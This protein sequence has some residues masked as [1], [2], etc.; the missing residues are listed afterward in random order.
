MI[1]NHELHVVFGS[2]G[3]IGNALVRVLF[4]KNKRVRAV[5]RSGRVDVPAGVET[6]KGDATDPAST[7][8][9]CLGASVVYHC[10]N[11]PYGEWPHKLVPMMNNLIEAA[12][13]VGAKLVYADN[14]YAYGKPTGALT[15]DTPY[16]PAG[17]KGEL[18][19]QLA[20]TL[21]N[22][23]KNGKVRAAIGRA[24]DFLGPNANSIAGDV[25]LPSL[26]TGK[27][28]MWI[29]SLDMP[30]T[31]SFLPDVARG[32]TTLGEREEALGQ[33]WHIPTDKPLTGRQ[34][35][36]MVCEEAGIK[37][38]FGV[39]T[40][41]MMSIVALFSPMVRE[42]LEEL[43]QFEAPFEME[44]KKFERMFAGNFTPHR[45]AIKETVSW[46]RQ[47]IVSNA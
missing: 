41:P 23:H 25:V 5:N 10:V 18:R 8:E 39:Y 28:A 45:N 17:R 6:A 46:Y 47:H 4:A 29:G 7:R 21:M 42:V 44:S 33:V 34:Y 15:E 11:V 14:L 36:Q 19:A 20:N 2:S 27:K 1:N 16:H 32:L 31:L 35:L 9:A 26:L 24:S 12:A 37:P 43:Y 22:A 38:N 30:H 3:G 13:T 40:R